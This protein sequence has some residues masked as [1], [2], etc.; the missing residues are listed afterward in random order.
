MKDGLWAATFQERDNRSPAVS[1]SGLA[2]PSMADI[3]LTWTPKDTAVHIL[4]T[5]PTP[6]AVCREVLPLREQ[7]KLIQADVLD[8]KS[9]ETHA[10]EV[11][12]YSA[13]ITDAFLTR[14]SDEEK[15]IVLRNLTQVLRKDGVL[16]TTWRIKE[17]IEG[18]DDSVDAKERRK[19]I[20]IQ[21]VASRAKELNVSFTM[22]YISAAW[23]YAER[24][25][26][27]SSQNEE[28]IKAMLENYFEDVTVEPEYMRVYDVSTKRYALVLA[29]RPKKD[30]GKKG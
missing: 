30:N 19:K 1:V 7:D 5:C 10:R 14:F 18:E 29:K 12:G 15:R 13:I 28:E 20:F 22:D 11:G 6:L 4:D 21:N 8:I 9:L 17:S 16:I 2:T 26:S 3:A 24:M 27:H 23:E 25:T